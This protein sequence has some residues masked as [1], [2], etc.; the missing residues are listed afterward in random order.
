MGSAGNNLGREFGSL[1]SDNASYEDMLEL[2]NW[3]QNA[4][5]K[6]SYDESFDDMPE[7]VMRKYDSDVEEDD[8]DSDDD[9][10]DFNDWNESDAKTQH[11]HHNGT[12]V[13][14]N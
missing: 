13:N 7:L 14:R 4:D 3:E 9:D 11:I 12:R 10:D 1:G 5:G 2:V 6:E 8:Y